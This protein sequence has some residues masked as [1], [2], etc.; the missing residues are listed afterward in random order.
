ML[1]GIAS[2]ALHHVWPCGTSGCT[3]F[4]IKPRAMATFRSVQDVPSIRKRVTGKFG[5]EFFDGGSRPTWTN[6]QLPETPR[7]NF[8]PRPYS[9]AFSRYPS[10]ASG[11]GAKYYFR[12][13]QK[14]PLSYFHLRKAGGGGE[15][16]V[17]GATSERAREARTIDNYVKER[18]R[19][20][21]V[22]LVLEGRGVKAYW[23]DKNFIVRLGVGAKA[24]DLTEYCKRDPD[25][26]VTL[27]KPGNVVVLHGPNKARVGTLASRMLRRMQPVLQQYTGKGAHFAGH[28]VKRRAVRKK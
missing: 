21:A 26:T 24:E 20:F 11:L 14:H 10:V 9:L 5:V 8:D 19:G 16:V 18:T 6:T 7:P 23:Q 1:Q 22:Q 3:A 15:A 25:V 4:A 12:E 17:V 2:R 27:N 28:P 13:G